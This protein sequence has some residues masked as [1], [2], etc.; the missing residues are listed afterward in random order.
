LENYYH[1]N[2]EA[3]DPDDDAL[4]SLYY[5][6]N[7]KGYD[8]TLIVQDLIE[9]DEIELDSYKWT[10]SEDTMDEGDYY[11][12]AK[13]TDGKDTSWVYSDGYL[14]IDPQVFTPPSILIDAPKKKDELAWESYEIKWTDDDPDSNARIKL[15]YNSEPYDMETW[16]QIDVNH[17]GFITSSDILYEDPDGVA[18]THTWD[19]SEFP[20]GTR[21]KV[22]IRIEDD[23]G[24][25][26]TVDSMGNILITQIPA[27]TN[28]SIVDGKM[29]SAGVY[30]THDLFPQLQWKAPAITLDMNYYG[31]IYE[32]TTSSGEKVFDFNTTD[33]SIPVSA[34]LEY[35]KGYYI[36]LYAKSTL[37]AYSPSTSMTFSVVNHKPTAPLIKISPEKAF[38]SD[39]L[40]CEI[41]NGSIDDDGDPLEYSYKWYKDGTQ[42]KNYDE[43]A[44]IPSDATSK[45]EVWKCVV[46]PFDTIENGTSSEASITIKNSAPKIIINSP[47]SGMK[48]KSSELVLFSGSVLDVDSDTLEYKVTSSIDG[49]LKSETSATGGLFTIS[50]KLS[51]GEHNI[52]VWASDGEAQVSQRRMITIEE[53]KDDDE[54]GTWTMI[55]VGLIIVIV[56]VVIIVVLVIRKRRRSGEEIPPPVEEYPS[57]NEGDEAFDE[58]GEFKEPTDETAEKPEGARTET[59]PPPETPATP[60][61]EEQPPAETETK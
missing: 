23:E 33:L 43:V 14:Y 18:D 47:A 37:G 8:G 26:D 49:E 50:K 52:T 31:D 25:N 24:Y 30:E 5:D 61:A 13:I 4:V 21:Y 40:R 6:D 10:W 51:P 59:T 39:S 36:E 55:M 11:V 12:Y 27:P 17:D 53:D 29:I 44:I 20:E 2:Y 22:R 58:Y 46:T 19:I 7:K 41:A 32:G 38:A 3:Y 28:L 1:I 16:A 60:P 42:Q 35:G 45:N 15:F 34:Q 56:I 48:A 57:E 54:E 9:L